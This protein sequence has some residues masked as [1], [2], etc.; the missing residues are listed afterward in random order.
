MINRILTSFLFSALLIQGFC[1]DYILAGQ[2]SGEYVHYSDLI[3]DSLIHL[4]ADSV[5]FHLDVDFDNINDLTFI[6]YGEVWPYG[7]QFWANVVIINDN[8]KIIASDSSFYW[9]NELID[10]DTISE[11]QNW[12]NN[13][14][15][16]LLLRKYL[17]YNYPPPGSV[18]FTGEFIDSG[19]LGFKFDTPFETYYGWI[20][21]DVEIT[22][23]SHVVIAKRMAIRGIT[24]GTDDPAQDF[25]EIILYPN[26][27]GDNFLLTIKN[28][29]TNN[30]SWEIF[31]S[32]GMIVTK[33]S[34]HCNSASI[35]TSDLIPGVYFL[36]IHTSDNSTSLSK[37]VKQ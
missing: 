16:T 14:T 19:Y 10:G 6:V 18:H 17:N 3:P 26:P 7:Y 33:G 9:A 35:N 25:S 2:S 15:N 13:S 29:N 11:N 28:E 27:C 22:D 4:N 37:F 5:Y 31:N 23:F 34:A 8:L 24:V 36:K 30:A 20:E 21:L 12:N 1:Q 32:K